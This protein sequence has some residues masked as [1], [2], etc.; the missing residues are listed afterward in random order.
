MRILG[1]LLC[2]TYCPDANTFL[3]AIFIGTLL[4]AVLVQ[5]WLKVTTPVRQNV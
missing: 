1:F 4:T 2:A 5:A 3:V